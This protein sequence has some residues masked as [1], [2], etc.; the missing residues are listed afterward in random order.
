MGKAN[1]R[2]ERTYRRIALQPLH[3]LRQHRGLNLGVIVEEKEIVSLGMGNGQI[4]ASSKAT[5][6]LTA[7]QR[8]L[9]IGYPGTC[10]LLLP[11]MG[12][13][14]LYAVGIIAC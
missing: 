6:G 11:T 5:V 14:S 9:G 4:V 7:Q 3:H 13:V 10:L 2:R 12:Q 1:Q 8:H